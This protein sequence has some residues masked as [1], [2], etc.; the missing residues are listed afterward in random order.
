[1]VLPSG[2]RGPSFR[3]QVVLQPATGPS[4]GSEAGDHF[5]AAVSSGDYNRDG[6]ADLAVG[7]PDES[8]GQLERVGAVTVV[9]GS[10]RGLDLRGARTF[11]LPSLRAAEALRALRHRLGER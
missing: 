10:A 1:M 11:T 3:E 4:G 9:Y 2:R 8:I 7:H 6:Y 5:G